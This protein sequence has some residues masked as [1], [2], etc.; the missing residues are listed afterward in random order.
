MRHHRPFVL[1]SLL[2]IAAC[3][4]GGGDAIDGAGA[5]GD[6]TAPTAD[7]S[8]VGGECPAA[9]TACGG[10][11][12]GTWQVAGFCPDDPEAAA[13]LFEHPFSDLPECQDRTANIVEGRLVHSGTLTFAATSVE[14]DFTEEA[15][16]TWGFT[17]ACLAAIDATATPEDACAALGGRA[18]CAFAAGVC[19]CDAVIEGKPSTGSLPLVTVDADTIT[20]DGASVDY[21][22]GEGSLVLDWAEH[23]VSWR[24]WVLTR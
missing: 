9:F 4:S 12:T 15:Q 3:G 23:P 18:T 16:V 6:A 5:G 14:A 20:I 2:V 21:C 8:G 19:T 10:E 22:A 17:T 7:A 13:A 24:Y 1:G 11:L